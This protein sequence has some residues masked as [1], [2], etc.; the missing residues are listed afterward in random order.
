MNDL[1]KFDATAS[2]VGYLYQC[3]YALFKALVATREQPA[4][5]IS[6]ERFDDV[7]FEQNGTPFEL[8]Q[9]KHHLGRSGGLGDASSDI[10]KTLRVWSERTTA[11]PRSLLSTRFFLITTAQATDGSAAALLR[12]D[13][14][15]ESSALT[16]L[17]ETATTSTNQS[18]ASAYA[19]FL[20]LR[21]DQRLALLEAV[22]VLDGS[23]GI[24]NMLPDI[25]AELHH[26]SRN[27]HLPLLVERLEGWWFSQVIAVLS[28][29]S[30]STIP[31]IAV[32]AKIEELRE[33]FRRDTLPVDFAHIGIDETILAEH[34]D[35]IF[36]R[37]LRRIEVGPKRI[38]WAIRDY[39][40]AFEQRSRWARDELLVDNE[41]AH[42][43]QGLVEAWEPRF[44]GAC[45]DL[46]PIDEQGKIRIGK[47]LFKWAEN[48][49]NFP[50]RSVRERFLTHGSLHILANRLAVGW[51]PDF[52]DGET[53][54]E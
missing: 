26:A 17:E 31:V 35:R 47:A 9:T 53:G 51:H 38:E 18:N 28:G 13:G 43:E 25:E 37:Q 1:N 27:E 29:Q 11:D 19:A 3:R 52:R 30:S 36:V 42:Y 45:E 10:W 33:S 24:L 16:L 7:A 8:I 22:T 46:D 41:I 6:I 20:A 50:L 49:A 48:E 5:E 39:Y 32:E 14:R 40:R 2:M 21:S 23:P 44:E 4:A 34:D 15:D 54:D 12:T